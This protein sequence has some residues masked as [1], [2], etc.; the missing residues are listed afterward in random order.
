MTPDPNRLEDSL[1]PPAILTLKQSD[2][3][4]NCQGHPYFTPCPTRCFGIICFAPNYQLATTN[5]IWARCSKHTLD[6]DLPPRPVEDINSYS[7]AK[8]ARDELRFLASGEVTNSLYGEPLSH[9]LTLGRT[10]VQRGRRTGRT[11]GFRS[12]GLSPEEYRQRR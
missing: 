4:T 7:L 1:G 10:R 8:R 2:A 9:I 3:V 6:Y 5:Q 11:D 12:K